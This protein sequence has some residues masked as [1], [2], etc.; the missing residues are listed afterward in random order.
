MPLSRAQFDLLVTLGAINEDERVELL[1]GAVVQMS[2]QDTN[3]SY[4]I[5]KLAGI[6]WKHCGSKNEVV[7]Q[8]P[9]A[10]S[11]TSEPEPDLCVAP[12]RAR[13]SD[14]PSEALLIV[15][16]AGASLRRDRTIK[17]RIYAAAGVPEYWVVN[18]REEVVEIFT[19]PSAT[20]YRKHEVRRR[21]AQLR[22][23]LLKSVKAS[24]SAILPPGRATR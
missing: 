12:R 14:H 10:A 7:V 16:V 21:G 5:T 23:H 2:P 15:E 9:F 19:R 8:G 11:D 3:H 17:A 18:L 4:C 1:H 6:L 24:V 22:P 20:G 13:W